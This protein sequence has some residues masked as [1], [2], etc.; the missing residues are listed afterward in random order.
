MDSP[1][2]LLPDDITLVSI[3]KNG[4]AYEVRIITASLA[5]DIDKIAGK[6]SKLVFYRPFHEVLLAI[7]YRDVLKKLPDESLRAIVEI[8]NPEEMELTINIK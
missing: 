4:S 7:A 3:F 8:E 5:G 2:K 1:P 6:D